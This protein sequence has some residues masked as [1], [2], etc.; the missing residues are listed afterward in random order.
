MIQ[1]G[2]IVVLV[3][4]AWGWALAQARDGV[5]YASPRESAWSTVG[6]NTHYY[7]GSR[8]TRAGSVGGPG[9]RGPSGK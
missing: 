9:V 6:G 5:G 1:K 3:L 4:A 2:V 8:S 7:H